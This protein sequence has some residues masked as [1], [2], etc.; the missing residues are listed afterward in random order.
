M[1]HRRSER[2]G[3]GSNAG[4]QRELESEHDDVRRRAATRGTDVH[5]AS[6]QDMRDILF[7]EGCAMKPYRIFKYET[8]RTHSYATPDAARRARDMD[9]PFRAKITRDAANA[10]VA[11]RHID[12]IAAAPVG[13]QPGVTTGAACGVVVDAPNATIGRWQPD[14]DLRLMQ[15][16]TAQLT[17]RAIARAASPE[18]YGDVPRTAAALDYGAA[19]GAVRTR[20]ARQCRA[21]WGQLSGASAGTSSGTARL[22]IHKPRLQKRRTAKATKAAMAAKAAR[23]AA[24]EA[25]AEGVDAEGVDAEEDLVEAVDLDGV[26]DFGDLLGMDVNVDDPKALG[27]L[28]APMAM[29]AAP[30]PPPRNVLRIT[31][32]SPIPTTSTTTDTETT[33][34]TD[35]R[36]TSPAPHAVTK[37]QVRV[38][39]Q[40][41]FDDLSGSLLRRATSFQ[42]GEPP[43]PPRQPRPQPPLRQ[44]RVDEVFQA[45]RSCAG[46]G[47]VKPPPPADAAAPGTTPTG[48]APGAATAAGAEAEA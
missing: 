11:E 44:S 22:T 41:N 10:A 26:V 30:P 46:A 45:R 36:G 32:V 35:A 18:A 1:S 24:K 48:T 3:R 38:C 13:P 7:V 39:R 37:P 4:R 2:T 27:A 40:L 19:A 33:T 5:A 28:E 12:A 14:E 23:I 16:I 47:G 43:R 9:A 8:G 31:T 6:G 25:E 20:T 42:F 29:P 34:D 15:A 17:Q 21:R